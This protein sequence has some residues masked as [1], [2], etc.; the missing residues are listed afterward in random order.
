MFLVVIL[1]SCC[2]LCFFFSSR[3]RHT[4]CALVTGV[5][6]CALPIYWGMGAEYSGPLEIEAT[7]DFPTKGLWSVHG[8]FEVTAK[9]AND[10]TMHISGK[11]PNG[12]RFEGEDGWIFVTR[13]NVG[14]TASDPGSDKAK[15]APFMASDPRILKSEIGENEIHL[16]EIGR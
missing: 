11:H 12:V 1:D 16:Y 15:N 7:A 9:Y 14:V 8:D 13:G 5:Q 10:I 4:R 3:R 2:V 6:T